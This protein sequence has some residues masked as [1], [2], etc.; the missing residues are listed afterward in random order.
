MDTA[1]CQ[2]CF[3][4]S[5]DDPINEGCACRES[6]RHRCGDP[7][8]EP[9]GFSEQGRTPKLIYIPSKVAL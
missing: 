2:N 4:N 5:L 8:P 9:D 6:N 3:S 7:S 1:T